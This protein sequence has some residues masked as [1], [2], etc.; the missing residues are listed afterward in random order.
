MLVERSHNQPKMSHALPP[1]SPTTQPLSLRYTPKTITFHDWQFGDK[2]RRRRMRFDV[3]RTPVLDCLYDPDGA[4]RLHALLLAGAPVPI[5]PWETQAM[6]A[7]RAAA[8]ATA[9]ASTT[10]TSPAL[11]LA[12]TMAFHAEFRAALRATDCLEL[13][14]MT[15]DN[16]DDQ[17]ARTREAISEQD[18]RL[19]RFS[20]KV[21]EWLG[22]V[23]DFLEDVDWGIN[24][25]SDQ[26]QWLREVVL[27]GGHVGAPCLQLC[28]YWRRNYV[29][30]MHENEAKDYNGMFVSTVIDALTERPRRH[31]AKART[32]VVVP[33]AIVSFWR[34]VAAAPDSKAAKAAIARAAKR[35]RA[36][37]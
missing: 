36:W 34:R 12:A 27:E 18:P 5:H 2:G 24:T 30:S 4:S 21:G 29:P 16:A 32:G 13:E 20:E 25:I 11:P 10:A 6:T 19:P 23:A 22:S 1:Y 9:A 35:A 8:A 14:G 26:S 3:A 31:W 37:A 7:F 17:L 28:R 33:T 15:R